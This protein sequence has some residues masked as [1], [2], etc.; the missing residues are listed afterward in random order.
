MVCSRLGDSSLW[1]I[2]ALYSIVARMVLV[3]VLIASLLPSITTTGE[4]GGFGLDTRV[5]DTLVYSNPSIRLVKEMRMYRD[6][7][8]YRL[9]ILSKDMYVL[10][11][12]GFLGKIETSFYPSPLNPYSHMMF[13]D[14]YILAVILCGDA[15]DVY[16][17]NSTDYT[18]YYNGYIEIPNRIVENI[19][20][21][22]YTGDNIFLYVEV[23]SIVSLKR[24]LVVLSVDLIQKTIV[25]TSV[26]RLSGETILT[27]NVYPGDVDGELG[28]EDVLLDNILNITIDPL[29]G[30]ISIYYGECSL[31][32][33]N[34]TYI[35]HFIYKD[36]LVLLTKDIGSTNITLWSI[37]LDTGSYARNSV[38]GG[39]Q[40]N[41]YYNIAGE[42][43]V[44]FLENPYSGY[45]MVYYVNMSTLDYI[46]VGLEGICAEK[47][48]PVIDYDGDGLNE[49]V[50]FN[51]SEIDIYYT[52]NSSWDRI[53]WIPD[54]FAYVDAHPNGFIEVNG[55]VYMAYSD[56]PLDI[57]ASR[58]IY[59][60]VI[61]TS[62]SLDKTPPDIELR[63][64]PLENN[65]ATSSFNVTVSVWE[66]ESSIYSVSIHVT[67]QDGTDIVRYEKVLRNTTHYYNYTIHVPSDKLSNG[68]YYV[69]VTAY[70]IDGYGAECRKTVIYRSISEPLLVIVSPENYS[71]VDTNVFNLEFYLD[72]GSN[73]SVYVYVYVDQMLYTILYNTT[74]LQSIP[75]NTTG[76]PDSILNITL[77]AIVSSIVN[78]TCINRSIIETVFIYK[79]VLYP[80]IIVYKPLENQVIRDNVVETE[81][82]VYDAFLSALSVSLVSS[83][84]DIIYSSILTPENGNHTGSFSVYL[85]G[86]GN[87]TLV[88]RARDR[89]GHETV[90]YRDIVIENPMGD[91]VVTVEPNLLVDNVLTNR[92]KIVVRAYNAT[93]LYVVVEGVGNKG[94]IAFRKTYTNES[95]LGLVT[96]S[97][98]L[99]DRPFVDGRYRLYVRA[100]RK[101]YI[102]GSYVE[103]STKLI[104]Y[105]FTIDNLPP[106]VMCY[107]PWS[108]KVFIAMG[109]EALVVDKNSV[110][111]ENNTLY[112]KG[113]NVSVMDV[114]SGYIEAYVTTYIVSGDTFKEVYSDEATY[115]YEGVNR[116]V[117]DASLF[118]NVSLL[119]PIYR[120][121][122]LDLL[123]K[124]TLYVVVRIEAND[125][126]HFIPKTIYLDGEESIHLYIDITEPIIKWVRKP[127]KYY[128]GNVEFTL[129]AI[130]NSQLLALSVYVNGSLWHSVKLFNGSRYN[131]TLSLK[132]GFYRL[133]IVV[134]DPCG[135][136]YNETYYVFIDNTPPDFIVS[137]TVV[138]NTIYIVVDGCDRETSILYIEVVS[139]QDRKVYTRDYIGKSIPVN[140]SGNLCNII[141]RVY[142]LLGNYREKRLVINTTTVSTTMHEIVVVEEKPT[143]IDYLLLVI[144]MALLTITVIVIVRR[145]S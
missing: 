4:L 63:I 111:L 76:I 2:R 96:V 26:S 124:Y 32:I 59:V 34:S 22:V 35:G 129:V 33:Q 31:A 122:S 57:E 98:D 15:V 27:Y 77:A 95:I 109:K 106:I 128:S 60:G 11:R 65:V 107:Y 1:C 113:I 93:S 24:E 7:G 115:R 53:K 62:A 132:E 81:F 134:A 126:I 140:C 86:S 61:N 80:E 74:G 8:D 18:L 110:V 89:A 9:I 138:N 85:L 79:D 141:V 52:H 78:N 117:W 71:V 142:D 121:A 120:N 91:I 123:D 84:G 104:R 39:M 12:N 66:N 70:N 145:K 64:W 5:D 48:Y 46:G 114:T 55:T 43:L 130:D 94:G 99:S 19:R 69:D 6:N 23:F 118:Y 37:L 68:V 73:G 143:F 92:D 112:L 38:Q 125:T 108:K 29:I 131:V 72:P 97:I 17:V 83:Y 82:Y 102:A 13:I 45:T 67:S 105:N 21:V 47:L 40:S 127:G 103:V 10:G 41:I 144:A 116:V 51:N 25:V 16:V 88:Y 75:I 119:V 100:S 58:S 14:G 56:K 87:Y 133:D 28:L 3:S 54:R 49:L 139:G 20:G 137:Y 44:L 42:N 136:K 50:Y 30:D 101:I 135:N 90:V 36:R